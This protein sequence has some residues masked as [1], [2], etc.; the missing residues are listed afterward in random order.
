MTIL[1]T[2]FMEFGGW[3]ANP[4]QLL[5]ERLADTVEIAVLPVAYARAGD[6]LRAAVERCDPEAVLC[7][8]QADGRAAI[9]VERVAL[10]VSEPDRLDEDGVGSPGPVRPGGPVGYWS[11]LPV[12]E[13]VEALRADG[14]PAAASRDAG[15]FVCNHV[16]FELLD[17]LARE[18]P[19]TI[20]GFV[21]LPLL[22]DQA[23]V[24]GSPSMALETMERAGRILLRI[25]DRA[26]AAV[27]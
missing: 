26:H 24:T 14:I 13:S 1:A 20:G 3:D 21:H 7:F 22:P 10:N 2:G 25:A 15:G 18:R 11:T 6:A 17:L 5:V 4:S 8:G 9:T 23:V 19:G 12:D 27:A 16:F